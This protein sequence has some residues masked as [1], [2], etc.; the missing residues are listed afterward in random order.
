MMPAMPRTSPARNE[1][2][3]AAGARRFPQ[4][5]A[6]GLLRA[7][8]RRVCEVLFAGLVQALTHCTRIVRGIMLESPGPWP[9]AR[10]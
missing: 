1:A 7:V 10:P 5:G 6:P 2:L 8:L 3:L 9:A 4:R